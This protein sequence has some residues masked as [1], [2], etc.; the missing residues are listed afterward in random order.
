MHRE[1]IFHI[2]NKLDSFKAAN[3]IITK[4]QVALL[5]Y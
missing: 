1:A 3:E 2:I 4:I 5:N